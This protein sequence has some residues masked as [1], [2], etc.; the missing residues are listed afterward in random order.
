MDGCADVVIVLIVGWYCPKSVVRGVLSK[1]VF[2][3]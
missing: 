2:S 1:G 3:R